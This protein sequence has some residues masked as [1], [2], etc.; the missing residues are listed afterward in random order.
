MCL[1]SGVHVNHE[2]YSAVD[3]NHKGYSVV[4]LFKSTTVIRV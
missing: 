2:E 3:F 1:L 4:D